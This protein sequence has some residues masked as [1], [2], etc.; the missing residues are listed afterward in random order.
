MAMLN[1]LSYNVHFG[2]HLEKIIYW[3]LQKPTFDVVCFQEFPKHA[4]SPF[5]KAFSGAKYGYRFAPFLQRRRTTF[6]ELTLFRKDQLTL[7]KSLTVSLGINS[8]ERVMLRARI[9]RTSLISILRYK[10]KT[11]VLVNV[12]LVNVAFNA[13][14]YKQITE[15]MSRLNR[16]STQSVFLGDFNMSSMFGRRKLFALMEKSG[17]DMQ[18]KRLSTHRFAGIKHQMDYIFW[19]GCRVNDLSVERVKFSDHYPISFTVSVR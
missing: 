13:L 17:F 1:V 5:L 6:G 14:R 2:K 3:L 4:I 15:I 18:K 10:K 12:H 19:K 11:I 9:P 16:N 8:G 7:V